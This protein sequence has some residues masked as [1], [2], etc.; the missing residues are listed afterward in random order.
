M[1][2]AAAG[3]IRPMRTTPS[4]SFNPMMQL[5][6]SCAMVARR[7]TIAHEMVNCIIGLNDKL[8]V[9]RIGRIFPAA[10]FHIDLAVG[11]RGVVAPREQ[12]KR[13]ARVETVRWRI[14]FIPIMTGAK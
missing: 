11:V 5:T 12:P 3:K 4:L 2:N 9:V 7:D 6:I 13:G 14:Q 8:G 10:A 1:W